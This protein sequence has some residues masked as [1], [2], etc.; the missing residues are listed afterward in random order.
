MT[1]S[2]L[3]PLYRLGHFNPLPSSSSS[4]PSS[5]SRTHSPTLSEH[6][7]TLTQGGPASSSSP[8]WLSLRVRSRASPGKTHSLYFDRD[9]VEGTVHL[10]LD[11][12]QHVLGVT[13]IV[14]AQNVAVGVD[15][16]PFLELIEHL[17]SSTMG[18]PKGGSSTRKAFTGKLSGCYT[19]PFAIQLPSEVVVQRDGAPI[20]FPLPPSCS[21]KGISA[22]IDYKIQVIVRRSTLRI[23]ST[24]VP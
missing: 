16:P 12:P 21:P 20:V 5:P 14:R 11:S 17:W 18:E 15:R 7:F 8:P 19:W 6:V 1:E 23:D 13:V 2:R 3:N 24:Y 9:V 22:Y 4:S 10:N